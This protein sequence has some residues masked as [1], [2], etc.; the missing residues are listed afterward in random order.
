MPFF[1][2]R[3]DCERGHDWLAS[4]LRQERQRRAEKVPSPVHI[5]EQYHQGKLL[6]F[7]G[8]LEE[9]RNGNSAWVR[10]L[11]GGC[12]LSF[13]HVSKIGDSR[14]FGSWVFG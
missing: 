4:G 6:G 11:G 14:L 8:L 3:D 10:F 5:G 2:C 12:E 13:E 1:W 9:R 7:V